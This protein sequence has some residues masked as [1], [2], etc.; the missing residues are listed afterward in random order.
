MCCLRRQHLFSLLFPSLVICRE[1]C[2]L[3]S[4]VCCLQKDFALVQCHQSSSPVTAA[5]QILPSVLRSEN[6]P[7]E[8]MTGLVDH[9]A[10]FHHPVIHD[11]QEQSPE[12]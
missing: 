8:I 10:L 6:T 11:H 1:L 3:E 9:V 7:G 12:G 4:P 2:V 5:K